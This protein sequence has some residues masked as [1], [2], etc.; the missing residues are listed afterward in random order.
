MDGHDSLKRD[1]TAPRF[2]S[3]RVANEKLSTLPESLDERDDDFGLLSAH[4]ARSSAVVDKT[5]SRGTK[6]KMEAS[7]NP[8]CSKGSFSSLKSR[9]SRADLQWVTVCSFF[10]IGYW[11]IGTQTAEAVCFVRQCTLSAQVRNML[12]TLKDTHIFLQHRAPSHLS[13]L[14]IPPNSTFDAIR[15]GQCASHSFTSP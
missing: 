8:F 2:T 9:E 12:Q 10:R 3:G 5:A 11:R 14:K 4:R 13:N 15:S 6:L 1:A 7:D